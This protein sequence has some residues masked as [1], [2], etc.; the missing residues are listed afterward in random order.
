[1]SELAI[2][3]VEFNGD[4]LLAAQEGSSEKIYVAITEVCDGIKLTKKQR[5]RQ[6]E[7]TQNDIV[8]SKGVKNLPLKFGGQVRNVVAI[9]LEFLPLWL[10]KISITPKM[11]KDKPEV[12]E[13]LVDYQLNVKDVLAN[14][15]VHEVTQII[16]KT[17][18]ES[19]QALL[20]QI[21]ENEALEAENKIMQ[22]KAKIHDQLVASVNVSDIITI[23][24]NIGVGEKK[25]FEFL[26]ATGILFKQGED[27]VPY[28]QYQ[29][30]GLFE[31]RTMVRLD[32]YNREFRYYTTKVTGKGKVF[33]ANLVDRHGGAE[34]INN[35]KL[36]EIASY[37]KKMQS[38]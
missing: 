37:V 13:K 20:A 19:L 28:Q 16:P 31:V 5:D 9:E 22:P 26:R 14:A 34:A 32:K 35:L 1:M 8:L 25:F 15:F 17:Y 23:A 29:N 27:N 4:V 30:S 18:K 10:A 2:K 38:N 7:N 12:V 36:K 24:K 6:V 3:E 33:I 21:E 11:K